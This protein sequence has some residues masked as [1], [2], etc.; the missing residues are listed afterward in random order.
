M[1]LSKKSK[2]FCFNFI[3]FLESTLNLEHFYKRHE[4]HHLSISEIIDS[5]KRGNL[6]AY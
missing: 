1:Q 6:N 3:A 4:P 2:T 5:E